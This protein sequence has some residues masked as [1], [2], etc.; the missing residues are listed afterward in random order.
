[1]EFLKKLY[2]LIWYLKDTWFGIKLRELGDYIQIFTPAAFIIWSA[3]YGT[4]HLSKVF[5]VTFLIAMGIYLILN[6]IFNNVRPSENDS[7]IPPEMNAEWSPSEGN[8][9]PSG[10]TMSAVTGGLFWFEID[11]I[12]GSIGL[13]LGLITGASRLIAKKHWIRDVLTSTV[14]STGCYLTA[15]FMFL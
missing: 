7:I 3:C 15:H 1:M 10:H 11:P 13:L 9:F 8:S 6:C 12:I 5:V 2:S 14:I 4:N